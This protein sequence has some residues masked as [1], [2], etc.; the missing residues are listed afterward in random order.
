VRAEAAV[1]VSRRHLRVAAPTVSA[2]AAMK[3]ETLFAPRGGL[4]KETDFRRSCFLGKVLKYEKIVYFI[5]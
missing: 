1:C 4:F 2:A 5:S 3:C